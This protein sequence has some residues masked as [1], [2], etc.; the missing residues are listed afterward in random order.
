MHSTEDVF[1]SLKL[2]KPGWHDTHNLVI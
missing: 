1:Q 2:K